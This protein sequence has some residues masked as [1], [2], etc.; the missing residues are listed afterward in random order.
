[1]SAA[2]GNFK[3]AVSSLRAKKGRSVLTMFGIIVGV[4]AVVTVVGL[5]DGIKQQIVQQSNQYGNDLITVRPGKVQKPDGV[6]MLANSDLLFGLSSLSGLLPSDLQAVQ[7]APGVKNA[8]P[9]G[10]ISGAVQAT[11]GPVNT[12]LPNALVIATSADFPV[13]L[14]QKLSSGSF[15]SQTDEGSDVA[16]IGQQVANDLFQQGAPLGNTFTFRGQTFIV[17]GVFNNFASTPLAGT[18]DFNDA[19]FIPDATAEQL[20]SNTLQY[21]TILAKPKDANATQ[22]TINAITTNLTA[23]R[24]GDQ[25]FSVLNQQQSLADSS[26]VLDL[27]T[28]LIAAVAAIALLVGGVGIMNIMLVSVTERM[29]EIGVRKA[30]GATNRQILGQFTLEALVLGAMGGICGDIA[31]ALIAFGLRTY[32]SFRPL[33]AWRMMLL[34]TAVSIVIGVIFGSAPAIKAAR[35]DPVEALRHE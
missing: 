29:H 13:V 2:R 31:A 5:G 7:S 21:Y 14:N 12:A 18:A 9:L 3:M 15:F 26:N 8:A 30:V 33:Y 11:T 34:A 17:G 6:K 35:K 23:E 28:T 16:V 4:A 19:I 22:T 24:H 20:S 1:M 25:N 27:L 32:T 10:V